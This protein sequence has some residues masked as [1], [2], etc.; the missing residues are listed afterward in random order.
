MSA[1]SRPTLAP[2]CCS[3]AARFTATVDLPTPPLPLA[4]AIVCLTPGS[5]SDAGWRM[6]PGRTLAVMRTSTRDT[7]GSE[8]TA[9]SAWPLNRS[10]TGQAGV[11]SSNVNATSPR[12]EMRRSLI[13]PRLTTS[14][15]RSGSTIVARDSST[16]CW[17]GTGMA[18]LILRTPARAPRSGRE[19]DRDALQVGAAGVEREDADRPLPAEASRRGRRDVHEAGATHGLVPPAVGVTVDADV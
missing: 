10:R 4:T 9:A 18:D 3:A 5:V 15:P 17:L 6:K 14:R 12:S 2:D 8:P 1:S 7:P 13:M 19:L 16:C 11:V